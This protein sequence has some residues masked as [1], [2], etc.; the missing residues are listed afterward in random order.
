M[1]IPVSSAEHLTGLRQD[2]TP[3]PPSKWKIKDRNESRGFMKFEGLAMTVFWF[4][5]FFYNENGKYEVN[6]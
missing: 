5:F 6:L 4:C 1:C 2:S 3:S